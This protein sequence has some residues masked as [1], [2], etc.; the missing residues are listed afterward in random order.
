M[1]VEHTASI[2]NKD[3]A[4]PN[5][6]SLS[7]ATAVATFI[8]V[9]WDGDKVR[10]IRVELSDG[11]FN[12][13]GGYDDGNYALT[14]YHFVA[15]EKLMKAWLRD[16]G[17]GYRSVRQ[18]Q[19]ETSTGGTFKAGPDGFDNE[20]SLAVEGKFLVG[21]D[22]WVNSDNFINALAF[23][24]VED[25][26]SKPAVD[27]PWFETKSV[28][29]PLATNNEVILT[30]NTSVARFI[31]VR[32]DGDKV[33]GIRVELSDGTFKQAGG[34]D[35]IDYR[36]DTYTFQEDETLQSLSLS[37]SGYGYGSLRRLEFTTN[38]GASFLAGPAGIDDLV[39]PPVAGTCIVGFHAWVNS[40]NFINA[41]SFYNTNDTPLAVN[42]LNYSSWDV[43]Y[44]NGVV[45]V[46]GKPAIQVSDEGG[47]KHG[48]SLQHNRVV[49]ITSG[50]LVGY[51]AYDG[52]ATLTISVFGDATFEA[53]FGIDDGDGVVYEPI[54]GV[55]PSSTKLEL[56]D[57]LVRKYA[58]IFMLNVDEVYWPS[59]VDAFLDRMIVQK[60]Q[61]GQPSDFYTGQLNRDTLATQAKLLDSYNT[62]SG[63]CLRTRADLNSPSDTQDWF[64]SV[65]PQDT[66]Q[67][68]AY[69]VVV[70]G[71]NNKRLDIVYWWFFNYNQGKTVA[72]TSWGNHVSDWEHIKIRLE[73]VDFSHPQQER[74]LDVIFDHHGDKETQAPVDGIAEF[75][76]CQALVHLA[77]GDHE[78]YPKAGVYSRPMG[79]HDYCKE[80][81]YRFN[82]RVG[83]IEIYQWDNEEK[84]FLSKPTN[85]PA[86]FKDSNWLGYKGRWGNWQRGDL[87][88]QVAQLESG[89]EGLTR[90]G[91]YTQP[92]EAERIMSVE[93]TASIGNKDAASSNVYLSSA[94]AVATFIGVRWDGDKVRG[95]R[96]ELSDGTSNQAGGYDDGNYEL[97]E[98]HF[99]EDEKL[100]TAWLRD[101][102]YGYR[103]LRQVQFVTSTGGTFKAGPDG[104]DNEVSLA[105]EGKSLVGFEAWVNSDNFINALALEV[106]SP[107]TVTPN[108]VDDT[109]AIKSKHSGKCLDLS[110]ADGS[111][112]VNGT[113]VFQW[114]YNGG[115]NQ[116]WFLTQQP[117]GSYLI[118]S[119][120]SGKC[121]DLSLADDPTTVN[122]TNVFQW[123]YNGGDNQKWFLT[124]QPDGS[125]L[126]QSKYS[127]KCLDLSLAD[128]PTTVNG[129]NVF[130]WDYNGGD[131]QKWFL[132]K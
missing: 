110:L 54:N 130:Q 75:S 79:T 16:S 58:P 6:V 9:R 124:Q 127:G 125:Y 109:F 113:D 120:Y 42:V 4:N 31:G 97:T 71:Q 10:G 96:V 47:N 81:A 91:E 69:A 122:G 132:I 95:I 28:G 8:G 63:A 29:N 14:E 30:S 90:P 123:D 131:N 73:N 83:T 20:V 5:S 67:V 118:Q 80:N 89:P 94:T 49:K 60:V 57:A 62:N 36:L 128:G 98:Y 13:A 74:I 103:S 115:D 72:G 50:N 41:L 87:F 25:T 23:V 21:F 53:K 92:T 107:I 48:M 3:A 76:G 65:Y 102:G 111:T 82:Q 46:D 68:T 126:I 108:G 43:S 17:Y 105:V 99:A 117:D 40:D 86:N 77:N 119:K 35:D 64:N 78:A 45:I 55:T 121:L 61:D 39:E 70:E 93:H 19:F 32:W 12:Q 7:S 34:Y 38:K 51:C 33:R 56:I 1:S 116:K 88:G 24:V 59:T 18:V 27:R 66:S 2:G 52:S 26:P 106:R 104:F 114:D 15:G 129:T 22:A 112:T 100:I 44:A 85:A 11:T 84:A 101:S 37:S